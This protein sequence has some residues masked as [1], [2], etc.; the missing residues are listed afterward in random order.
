MKDKI[1]IFDLDETLGYFSQISTF[2]IIIKNSL[3]RELD[4]DE[5]NKL[6]D[7][8]PCILR[9]HIIFILQ[10]LGKIPNL[11]VYVYTNNQIESIWKDYLKNYFHYKIEKELFS[12]WIGPYKIDNRQIEEKR[13]S[14]KKSY[15]DFILCTNELE[16]SKICF[17]DDSIHNGMKHKNLIY[18]NIPP[19]VYNYKINQLIKK[20]AKSKLYDILQKKDLFK[21]RMEVEIDKMKNSNFFLINKSNRFIEKKLSKRLLLKLQLFIYQKNE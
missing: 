3:Q 14:H 21:E 1:V 9:P 12:R 18:I 16:T 4:Q 10:F 5:F 11:R 7:L 15:K 19:Y 6:L 13:T 17:I 8:Y 2:W 20:F